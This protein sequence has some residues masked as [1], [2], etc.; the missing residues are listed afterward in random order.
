MVHGTSK[1]QEAKEALH[2]PRQALAES[3]VV[4]LPSALQRDDTH[5][6]AL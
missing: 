4:Q 6:E 1:V 5:A 3:V 2:R